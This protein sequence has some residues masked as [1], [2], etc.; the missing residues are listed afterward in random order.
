VPVL[1]EKVRAREEI[2]VIVPVLKEKVRA[3]EEIR[4]NCARVQEKRPST[5]TITP[6]KTNQTP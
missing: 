5:G 2:R 6:R 3:R 1:K 4:V